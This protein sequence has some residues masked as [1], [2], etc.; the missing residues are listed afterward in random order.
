MELDDE[1]KNVLVVNTPL[2]L[3]QYQRLPFGIASAPALFQKYLEQ[4]IHGTEGRGNYI[5][6]IIIAAETV[7]IHLKRLEEILSLLAENG[8]RCRRTKCE[9]L[10][11]KLEYLGR[12]ISAS[13][14]LP[15]EKGVQ[16]VKQLPRPKNVKEVEAFLGKVNY[17][18]NF[19]PNFSQLAAPI[20]HLRRK[21]IKFVWSI[22][23]EQAFAVLKRHIIEATELSH[24]QEHLLIVLATDASSYGIGA[25]I[26]HRHPDGSERPIAFASKTLNTHQVRYSQ[27]EKE[28]LSIIFGVTRFHQY[29][30]GHKFIL[31]MDHKPLYRRTADHSN[32]DALSRLPCGPDPEFDKFEYCHQIENY[33]TPINVKLLQQHYKDDRVLNR[34][35]TFILEGWPSKLSSCE[36]DLLPFFRRQYAFIIQN[37]LVY[38]QSDVTRVVVNNFLHQSLLKLLHEGHWGVVKMKQ[39]A[40]QHC[41]WHQIDDDIEKPAPQCNICQIAGTNP[42]QQYHE[43]PKPER[44]WQRV[45]IDFAGPVFN[46]MWLIVVDAFSQ[47]PFVVQL[48]TTTSMDAIAALSTIFSLEGLPE[49]IVSDNGPQLTSD[50]FTE[51]CVRNGIDHVKTAPFYRASNGLAERFVRTF[52]TSVKK[53]VDDGLS[54]NLALVKY[55]ATYRAI[56][57]AEGKSPAELL[58]G[59]TPRT[60]LTLLSASVNKYKTVKCST[61]FLPNKKVYVRHYGRDPK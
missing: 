29:L 57:N 20:N 51:F 61:K 27:I 28:A 21:D 14:I 25:V 50:Q 12:T 41:W 34:F 45:H 52:K 9:F 42:N 36:M 54:L 3:F 56:P 22:D 17:Y 2:K 1:A 39:L 40:R 53:N 32:A 11:E 26:A 23:Q 48:K 33:D 16:A 13:G 5:D 37:N 8:I 60:L 58:H 44:P 30:F 38:L 55:L 15:D 7:D 59:R 31:V 24:F 49:T 35:K 18:H 4:L 6:D 10:V 47:F 46:S 43:W 19:I